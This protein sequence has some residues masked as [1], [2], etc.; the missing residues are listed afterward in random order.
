MDTPCRGRNSG[1]GRRTGSVESIGVHGD[2]A[3]FDAGMD[4]FACH[5][6]PAAAAATSSGRKCSVVGWAPRGGAGAKF[7]PAPQ[8]VGHRG[9]ACARPRRGSR[10]RRAVLPPRSP[11]RDRRDTRRDWVSAP[12]PMTRTPSAR[13]GASAVPSC[14]WNALPAAGHTAT[15]T[16]GCPLR[17]HQQER[18]P[19][20]VIVAARSLELTR[21][22]GRG[23]RGGDRRGQRGAP[24]AGYASA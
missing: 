22:A 5:P 15:C 21:Q 16:P 24:G 8:R 2:D 12:D 23:E 9:R 7:V 18:D 11:R 17:V 13:S 10:A 6:S 20:A 1:A 19:G 4:A 14:Q 3:E